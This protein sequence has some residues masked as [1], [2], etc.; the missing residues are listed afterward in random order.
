MATLI[1]LIRNPTVMSLAI[2]VLPALFWLWFWLRED[3]TNPEPRRV[4]AATFIAG[5]CATVA[6]LYLERTAARSIG[7]GVYLIAAWAL[8]EEM[9]KYAAAIGAALMRKSFD[10]PV[11]AMVYLVTAALGFAA[12]ENVL[13]LSKAFSMNGTAGILLT[14]NLRFFGAML[15]HIVSSATV[16]FGIAFGFYER[17]PKRILYTTIALLTATL[18]HTM[19][20]FFILQENG[21]YVFSVLSILWLAVVTIFLLFEE[22][23]RLKPQ[24]K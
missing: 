20:N 24:Q 17:M 18:L 11:D 22:S 13:F 5:G 15:V 21:K 19:F 23:K 16:G 14:G 2:G 1:N 10:E 6:A 9:T 7:Q 12:V 8:I 3:R 4:L